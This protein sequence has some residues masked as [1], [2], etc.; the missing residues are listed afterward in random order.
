MHDSSIAAESK[1]TRKGQLIHSSDTPLHTKILELEQFKNLT[2][3][4]LQ[5][6]KRKR[7]PYMTLPKH[8]RNF[9][10]QL[11]IK[12]QKRATVECIIQFKLSE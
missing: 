3:M 5:S 10:V 1:S 9:Q 12:W 6:E 7:N 11:S 8:R 2:K 4:S